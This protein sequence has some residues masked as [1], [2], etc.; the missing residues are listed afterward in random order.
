MRNLFV[1]LCL[2]LGGCAFNNA[3]IRHYELVTSTDA[4]GNKTE[5]M[6]LADTISADL[7]GLKTLAVG[8]IKLEFST[9]PVETV[10]P[11][12]DNKGSFVHAITV[13]RLPGFYT[14]P[15]I[16]AQSVANKSFIDGIFSGITGAAT[17]I[18]ALFVTGGAAKA[19][20]L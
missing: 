18:G 4:K 10:E 13:K 20:G 5:H 1:I 11:V 2:L 16:K 9:D 15:S 19:V 14:S 3:G 12:F 6:A 17:S 8:R 7:P